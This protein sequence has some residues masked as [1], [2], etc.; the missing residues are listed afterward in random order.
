M[1]DGDLKNRIYEAL[2]DISFIGES[3]AVDKIH[4]ILEQ[5]LEDR[6]IEYQKELLEDYKKEKEKG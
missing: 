5:E 1:D 3:V 2:R 6:M 4:G